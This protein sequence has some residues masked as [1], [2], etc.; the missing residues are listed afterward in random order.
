MKN[1]SFQ[2]SF[3]P[4]DYPVIL[5][6]S[7]CH[8][9]DG[10]VQ[11]IIKHDKNKLFKFSGLLSDKSEIAID[12]RNID[13]PE[14]GSVIL[15]FRDSFKTGSDAVIEILRMLNI[16]KYLISLMELIPRTWRDTIYNWVSRNR[17]A[18][19]KKRKYCNLPPPSEAHRFV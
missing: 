4:N 7:Q 13:L 5:F 15:L 12:N 16:S 3:A 2:K 14:Q 9:C 8:L 10:L 1:D 11:W 17:Y 19:L 18:I 6:D